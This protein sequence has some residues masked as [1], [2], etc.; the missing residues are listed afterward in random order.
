MS[1]MLVL[2]LGVW[3]GLA[4]LALMAA[5]GHGGPY[6]EG[7]FRPGLRN[8]VLARGAALLAASFALWAF[9]RLAA[10][11]LLPGDAWRAFLLGWSLSVLPLAVPPLPRRG[12]GVLIPSHRLVMASL[13]LTLLAGL[14]LALYLLA[15]LIASRPELIG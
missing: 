13:L 4:G 2:I 3:L 12:G 5:R 9:S 1:G 14:G 15:R 7:P 8:E 10:L 11:V 6:E